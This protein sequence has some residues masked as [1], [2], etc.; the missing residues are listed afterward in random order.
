MREP[1]WYQPTPRGLEGKIGEKLARL[2]DL[3]AQWRDEHRDE[4][5]ERKRKG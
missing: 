5:R 4:I 2:A 3:D 1:R